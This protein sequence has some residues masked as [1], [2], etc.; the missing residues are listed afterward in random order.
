[1]I[2]SLTSLPGKLSDDAALSINEAAAVLSF[3]AVQEGFGRSSPDR[4]IA[5]AMKLRAQA[6]E[7]PETLSAHKAELQKLTALAEKLAREF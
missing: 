7:S 1:M 6:G 2:V 4:Y 5:A 3:I